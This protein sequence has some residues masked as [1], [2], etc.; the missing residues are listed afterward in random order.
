VPSAPLTPDDPAARK[1]GAPPPPAPAGEPAAERL[2]RLLRTRW[3]AGPLLVALVFTALQGIAGPR[4]AMN[5]DS[6]QYARVALGYLG[7]SP[8]DAA[9]RAWDAG[10]ASTA[11]EAQRLSSVDPIRFRELGSEGEGLGTCERQA[12]YFAR[13]DAGTRRYERIFEA[14]I[15]YPL[16]SAPAVAVLG[17]RLGLWATSVACT[18]AAGFL[19]AALLTAAGLRPLSAIAGQLVFLLCPLGRWGVHPLAEGALNAAVLLTLLGAWWLL[20]RGL[21]RGGVVCVLGLAATSAVKYSSGVLLAVA[22]ALAA[23]GCALTARR[24]RHA[25]TA[26]LVAGGAVAAVLIT[27]GAALAG[28][29][30]STETLQD[31]FTRHYHRPDVPDPWSLLVHL[32]LRFWAYFLREQAAGPVLAVLS[33]TGLWLLLRRAGRA[34]PLPQPVAAGR[35]RTLGWLALAGVLLGVLTVA[36][37]PV[38]YEYGRLGALEW[39]PAVLGLPLL[40]EFVCGAV[41]GWARS[42]PRP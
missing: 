37:H 42:S 28:A 11:A 32:D 6:V 9:R 33:G 13:P 7:A 23:A 24:S 5:G 12:R 1:R 36:A 22:L 40:V 31:T 3:W 15:G 26:V 17:P 39:L 4:E 21:L 16:L 2:R 38:V 29:P 34:A 35:R 30:G 20:R 10:C 41:G 19:A 18:A 14:R 25:G 27:A 8:E